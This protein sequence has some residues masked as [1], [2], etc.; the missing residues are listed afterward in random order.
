MSSRVPTLEPDQL[1][2]DTVECLTELLEQA[3]LGKVVGIAFAAIL[4]GRNFWVNT[5]GE[6]YRSPVYTHGTVGVL[7]TKLAH[8][9]IGLGSDL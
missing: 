7:H 8:K 3:K 2:H 1:S 4:R 5:A 9:I 6:A